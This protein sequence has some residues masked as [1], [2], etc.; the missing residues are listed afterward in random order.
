MNLDNLLDGFKKAGAIRNALYVIGFLTVVLKP[1]NG[2]TLNLEG[3]HFIPTLILPVIA[4]LLITGFILDVVMS[5]IYSAEQ[6][7]EVV[8]RYR[9]IIR[10]NLIMTIALLIAWVPY[11]L[12]AG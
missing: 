7:E 5:R 4:P 12:A 2:T 8:A 1:D 11:M 3:L 10:T 6:P 9:F